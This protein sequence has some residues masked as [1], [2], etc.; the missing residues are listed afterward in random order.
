MSDTS[1]DCPLQNF[2]IDTVVNDLAVLD[3]AATARD[4]GNDRIDFG[5]T[6]RLLKAL[7]GK[8][9]YDDI[10]WLRECRFVL[11]GAVLL[12]SLCFS[13]ALVVGGE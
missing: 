10:V 6:D 5:I 3:S 13:R 1:A 12:L 9:L 8:V 7:L 2:V 4:A 11:L